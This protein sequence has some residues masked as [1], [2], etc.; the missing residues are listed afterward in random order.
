M[1]KG[2]KSRWEETSISDGIGEVKL[3][4][5]RYFMDFVYQRMLD[6]ET[7][8]WR[9]QRCDDWALEP[10]LDRLT[11]KLRGSKAAFRSE[12]LVRFKFAARGRRGANPPRIED[13]DDWWAL[14][15]HHGLATPLLDWTAS[16]F[17]AAY[18]AF[19]SLGTPQ[20][21]ARAIFA[22]HLPTVEEKVKRLIAE[23]RE[24]REERKKRIAEG[25]TVGILRR[26]MLDLPIRPEVKF[27]R[28]MSDE[29]QRLVTQGGL[30]SRA[31]NDTS[32]E[33]WVKK[34]C[35][36]EKKYVLMK[37]LAPNS[38]REYSLRTL[39]RMNINHLSLFPD[40]YG[41]SAYSNLFSQ[42][43]KY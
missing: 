11:R 28:P 39:N 3:F 7:Y 38:D 10:T 18:F 9:G 24:R 8:I 29:N 21:K 33:T 35:A 19:I 36:G 1:G 40:L 34:N 15:Q 32:I 20:T 23:E 17:V 25:A 41:A 30:F 43:E 31:P 13:E 27:I 5:W 16:P 6:Y 2:R 12:H 42:I 22:L 4:S 26:V 37:I 14:G